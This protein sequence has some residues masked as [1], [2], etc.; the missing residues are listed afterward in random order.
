MTPDDMT[1][2]YTQRPAQTPNWPAHESPTAPWRALRPPRS[3]A[4]CLWGA[5]G[6]VL[7]V[8]LAALIALAALAPAPAPRVAAQPHGAALTVILTDTLLTQAISS[9]VQAGT[10]SLAQARAHIESNGRIVV[11]GQLAGS[12]DAGATV[13]IVTQPYVSQHTLAVKVLR[14]GYGGVALPTVLLDSMRDQINASLTRSSQVSLG[15]GKT[16]EVS[17]VTCSNG[18]MTL[19]YAPVS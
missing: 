7:G 3:R 2:P 8:I 10:G 1:Q 14:V 12:S 16:L 5:G 9:N 15:V 17:G 18:A 4:G 13:T 6:F 11:T 19:T